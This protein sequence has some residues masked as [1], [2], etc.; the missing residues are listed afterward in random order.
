[1]NT[2]Q[3]IIEQIEKNVSEIKQA[4]RNK[5]YPKKHAPK[6]DKDVL[7]EI[8]GGYF[9]LHAQDGKSLVLKACDRTNFERDVNLLRVMS[10]IC[11]ARNAVAVYNWNWRP[12]RFK[13]DKLYLKALHPLINC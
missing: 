13:K 4:H 3:E 7:I 1:M 12:V 6:V 9:K 2:N 10:Y 8:C 11:G 5:Q